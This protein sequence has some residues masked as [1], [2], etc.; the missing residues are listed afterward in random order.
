MLVEA[1]A[2][3]ASV[4]EQSPTVEFEYYS[5]REGSGAACYS[6]YKII[7]KSGDSPPAGD[8]KLDL[9]AVRYA[10]EVAGTTKPSPAVLTS[11]DTPD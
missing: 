3:S 7:R 1:A 4:G 8:R 11:L 5:D 9:Q 6:C 2:C 10:L